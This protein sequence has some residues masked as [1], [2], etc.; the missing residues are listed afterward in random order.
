MASCSVVG[1]ASELDAVDAVHQVRIARMAVIS[2]YSC[3]YVSMSVNVE[4]H[5]SDGNPDASLLTVM[6]RAGSR[7]GCV[8]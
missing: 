1:I 5:Y 8:G 2:P 6:M 3:M 4:R 7:L